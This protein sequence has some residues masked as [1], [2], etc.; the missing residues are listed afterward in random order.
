MQ[1]AQG[2]LFL[3]LL[4][5]QPISVREAAAEADLAHASKLLGH[6]ENQI[7]RKVYQQ[8]GK[9]VMPIKQPKSAL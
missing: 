9:T 3:S 7:M 8:V 2:A 1:D 5:H 4:D 6:T